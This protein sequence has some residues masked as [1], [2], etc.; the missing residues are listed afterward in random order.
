M[1]DVYKLYNFKFDKDKAIEGFRK[2]LIEKGLDNKHKFVDFI[3][4]YIPDKS[5]ATLE[6]Y[7]TRRLCN[8]NEILQLLYDELNINLQEA[9][10]PNSFCK[11]K[12]VINDVCVSYQYRMN[13]LNYLDI[14]LYNSNK[15]N[16][17][18]SVYEFNE[19]YEALDLL[20]NIYAYYNYLIQKYINSYLSERE[21]EILDML[22][23]T[24]MTSVKT[25]YQ[26]IDE[27]KD[28]ENIFVSYYKDNTLCLFEDKKHYLLEY[29]KMF[30]IVADDKL[31][32]LLCIIPPKEKN[33]LYT[34]Y[35]NINN[36]K[37]V[38]ALVNFNVKKLNNIEIVNNNVSDT[39]NLLIDKEVL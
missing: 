27:K 16:K 30:D 35:K 10:L 37:M 32:D 1:L 18:S 26:F 5:K 3:L 19:Y 33:I 4:K 25:I 7:Y 31:V 28:N 23:K 21:K 9:F 8:D 36:G 15:L 22:V 39:L 24:P 34:I 2:A 38:S 20:I 11:S 6:E 12:L 14:V 13:I 17:K 29:I